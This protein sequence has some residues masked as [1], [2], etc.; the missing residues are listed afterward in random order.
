MI[1]I[2]ISGA[3]CSGK[4]SLASRLQEYYGNNN[5]AIISVDSYYRD[6]S[7]L[8]LD[9]R[10]K[11]NYDAPDALETP[12][13]VEHLRMLSDGKAVDVPI[14]D[15]NASARS[16][17]TRSL[18]PHDIVIV[19]GLF[20]LAPGDLLSL[21]NVKLFVDADLDLCLARRIQ[22]DVCNRARAIDQVI[23]QFVNTV[24][25][26]F[27]RYVLPTKMHADLIVTNNQSY[28]N[29]DIAPILGFIQQATGSVAT[30][31]YMRD[32]NLLNPSF[33]L[34]DSLNDGYGTLFVVS[35][36]SGAGKSSILR[37]ALESKA[38]S[39]KH[40][41]AYTTRTKRASEKNGEDYI[42]V[43]H[44]Y[45]S[46]IISSQTP[47]LEYVQVFGND[48]WI[49]LQQVDKCLSFGQSCIVD[50]TPEALRQ[51]KQRLSGVHIVSIFICPPSMT[52]LVERTV[53]RDNAVSVDSKRYK[54]SLQM[55]VNASYAGYDYIIINDKTK[56]SAVY[57][58]CAILTASDLR[59]V[60]QL[61]NNAMLFER[62]KMYA[63]LETVKKEVAGLIP[64][65]DDVQLEKMSG[66]SNTSYKLTYSG[67]V[68]YL[69]VPRS[70][71]GLY[72]ISYVHEK[73]N[74][75]VASGLDLYPAATYF[76]TDSGVYIAPFLDGYSLMTPKLFKE[77][78]EMLSEAISL[79]RRLHESCDL[80]QNDF[81]PK[82]C[83]E[84]ALRYLVSKNVV[85]PGDMTRITVVCHRIAD[86][87]AL[88]AQKKVACHNDVSPYNFLKKTNAPMILVDWE[89]SGRNDLYWDLAKLALESGLNED[90]ECFVLMDY[91]RVED[92]EDVHY[93]RLGLHKVLVE[94][95]LAVWSKLQIGINNDAVDAG[96]FERMFIVHLD[97][98]RKLIGSDSLQKR[99]RVVV[100]Q[101][102]GNYPVQRTLF[103]R[104]YYDLLAHD[105]LVMHLPS[106]VQNIGR[107]LSRFE[108]GESQQYAPCFFAPQESSAHIEQKL[109]IIKPDAVATGN[110]GAIIQ[111]IERYDDLRIIKLQM[112]SID[113]ALAAKLYR[114]AVGTEIYYDVLDL[115]TSGPVVVMVLAG[116][117]LA[118]QATKLKQDLRSRF[119]TDA[120]YNVIHCSDTVDASYEIALFFGPGGGLVQEKSS[121]VIAALE[122]EELSPDLDCVP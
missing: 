27:F 117:N 8:T 76:N 118:Q 47:L 72:Q 104:N 49:P 80:L 65:I 13:L 110:C 38:V 87:L 29:Q 18:D 74:M 90:Q 11:H 59:T 75:V 103:S 33:N 73:K 6:R 105:D 71:D 36:P 61:K 57:D 7:D 62:F 46:H 96:L 120:K 77:S 21:C 37:A 42:F 92:L 106:E 67:G 28:F 35:G 23:N 107:R 111:E 48:Y 52:S 16:I 3:S 30:S 40:I 15:F 121:M 113:L 10:R 95:W 84:D 25:P 2:G 99:L 66:L 9:E 51:V 86:L 5:C 39:L 56:E 58:L 53:A 88:T 54:Y 101:I 94:F 1:I 55:L 93:A 60:S 31:V 81:D 108:Y 82:R 122:Q 63:H 112:I 68:S 85:L 41:V 83:S 22:K 34:L 45:F 26:M 91:F 64:N 20:V 69:R 70:R 4:S 98:C 116:V 79:I 119:R 102:P 114:H 115:M 109:V 12:L 89:H 32:A 43:A 78:Q 24:R 50:L 19:E 97:N 17:Q 44:D 100:R 14:F